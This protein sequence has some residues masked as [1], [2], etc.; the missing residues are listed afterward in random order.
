MYTVYTVSEQPLVVT[1]ICR[2][3]V[4]NAIKAT[5]YSRPGSPRRNI[6][7]W[8]ENFYY[9]VVGLTNTKEIYIGNLEPLAVSIIL[10]RK[11]RTWRRYNP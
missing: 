5:L 3:T 8:R 2:V 11:Q 6:R 9:M 4:N 7:Q 1:L 10:M